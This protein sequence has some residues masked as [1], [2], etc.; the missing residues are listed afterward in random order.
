MGKVESGTVRNGINVRV[1]P[2]NACGKIEKVYIND[3]EVLSAAPG[4]NIK[5]KLK[6]IPEDYVQ[7]G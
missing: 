4:E 1:M 3:V 2:L 7:K 5:V 6:G